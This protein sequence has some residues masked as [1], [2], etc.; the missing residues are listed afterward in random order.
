MKYSRH[1][2]AGMIVVHRD[3]GKCRFLVVLSRLTKKP[4]WEFPK[5][6]VDPGE[7]LLQTALRELHEETG[8]GEDVLSVV[9]GFERVEDYRFTSGR[10]AER[11]LI[12]KEV[13]YYLA[14]STSTA[15]ELS[16]DEL[17]EYAWLEMAEAARRL[18]YPGRRQMLKDAAALIGC[19]NEDQSV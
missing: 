2:S 18:K 13:T 5:G 3:G 7:S 10:T 19:G 14:V 12:H 16:S 11:T 9:P 4:L 17:S 6:G 15:I 8:L 1:V